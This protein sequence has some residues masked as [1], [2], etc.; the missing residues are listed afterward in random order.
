VRARVL[1]LAA[2]TCG[3][4]TWTH[5]V[6][7]LAPIDDASI[8]R[9]GQIT[10]AAGWDHIG[11]LA[12]GRRVHDVKLNFESEGSDELA[13]RRGFE[14]DYLPLEPRA[15]DFW[16]GLVHTFARP[17]PSRVAA[18][19]AILCTCR[20]HPS[21]DFCLVHCTYG[22]DRT[23]LVVGEYRVAC[24]GWTPEQAYAE[25]RAHHFHRFLRG[26]REAW[27]AFAARP[28]Q[29]NTTV[30]PAYTMMRFSR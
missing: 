27:E 30:L 24:D 17:D 22:H 18:A 10:S 11:Q 2:C 6:P 7:N 13:A 1:V 23:G 20:A 4:T 14:V 5:G 29:S 16:D 15:D 25:M 19:V 21:T 28:R 8:Y 3:P 9:S 12:H 26:L